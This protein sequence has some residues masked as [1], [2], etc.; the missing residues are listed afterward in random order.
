M[1]AIAEH[2]A[3]YTPAAGLPQ[4]RAAIGK[5]LN[6]EGLPYL[7]REIMATAGASGA[8]LGALQ[9]LLSPGDEVLYPAPY[10]P[11]F[12]TKTLLAGGAPVPLTTH[13]EDGFKLRPDA[14]RA[15]LTRRSRVLLINNPCNPT[16]VV[17]GAQELRALADVALEAGLTVIADE[18]YGDLVYEGD[19]FTSV[20]ALGPDVRERTLVV[21]SFSK[22]HAMTGWRIGFAAGPEALIRAMT[23]LQEA[24]FV[25]L[26]AVSQWA[27]LAALAGAQEP[28]RE[29]VARFAERH[30]YV[31]SRIEALPG[32]RC[33]PARGGLFFFPDLGR[34]DTRDLCARAL[35]Q[36]GVA[37]VPG[38]HFGVPR[39]V[40]ISFTAGHDELREG[41][42][43]LAAAVSEGV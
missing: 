32:V 26:P 34:G 24:T 35:R 27:A 6:E 42:D 41:L 43:R 33:A 37:V 20:A 7:S 11:P 29:M 19:P 5:K 22:S 21:R 3:R 17:Y 30:R 4:L 39:C 23:T 28:R 1:R 38:A 40:R 31:R 18:V 12:A 36:H 16:G 15:A 2:P 8:L 14:V 13:V 9:A 10:Y 25:A